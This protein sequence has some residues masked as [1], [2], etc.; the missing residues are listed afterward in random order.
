[1]TDAQTRVVILGA[2]P[3]GL[4]AAW[5]L[6]APEQRGRHDVTIYQLGWQAGGLCSTGRVAP[7][8]WVNQNG[9]HYLFGAYRNSFEICAE[10]YAE[11]EAAGHREFGR[12]DEQFVARDRV[13]F[14][15]FFRGTW[16]QWPVQFPTNPLRPGQGPASPGPTEALAMALQWIVGIGA[17]SGLLASAQAS[18]IP[19]GRWSRGLK[20][21]L[22]SA[23]APMAE[24]LASLVERGVQTVRGGLSPGRVRTLELALRGLRSGV[25]VLLGDSVDTHLAALRAWIIIDLATTVGLGALELVRSEI[26]FESLDD[27]ELRDWL[28]QWGASRQSVD[29]PL[30]MGAYNAI[31]AYEDGDVKRPNVSAGVGLACIVHLLLRYSGSVAY[32]ITWGIGDA[33]IAPIVAA[34]RLRGVRFAFFHRVWDVVPDPTGEQLESIELERQVDL[35]GGDPF[36]YDPFVEHDGRPVWPDAPNWTQIEGGRRNGR[37]LD[38]FYQARTGARVSLRAGR[39]FDVAIGAMGSAVYRHCATG[40]VEQKPHWRRIVEDLRTVETQSLRLWFRPDLEGLGWPHGPPITT[41]F[42]Q[43]FATWEDPTPLLSTE[44]WDTPPRTLAHLFGPLPHPRLYPDLD[45]G[46]EYEAQQQ[47]KAQM[48]AAAWMGD[49]IGHLWPGAADT[50]LG[51]AIDPTCLVHRQIRANPGPLQAYTMITAGTLALRPRAEDSGYTNFLLA[52][53]WT[54]NGFEV[55]SFEGAVL[56]GYWASRAM[57]GYPAEL[58]GVVLPRGKGPLAAGSTDTTCT[59]ERHA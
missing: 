32:Q 18:D 50:R 23:Q 16:T 49:A 47:A 52:G 53:D 9:T 48:H 56:S 55:G 59:E 42:A 41:S 38:S 35:V 1:M 54:R 10:A 22:R 31:A 12:Y 3:A 30:V 20:A 7:Q 11:L 29:S 58:R 5:A 27:I 39:D 26:S 37:R 19:S 44:H 43:P 21:L 13:V 14:A 4:A 51:G 17:G 45:S 8:M 46:D 33:F 2:G 40:L 28:R 34:L 57:S 25:S 15:Q 36:S 6:T 24:A